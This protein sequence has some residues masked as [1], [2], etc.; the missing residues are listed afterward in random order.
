M[1]PK[2]QTFLLKPT[3]RSGQIMFAVKS[4]KIVVGNVAK[5]YQDGN[6]ID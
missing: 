1:D 3:M 2:G 6:H 5:S 4:K